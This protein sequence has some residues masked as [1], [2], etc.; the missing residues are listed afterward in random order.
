MK[1]IL[2]IDDD[3][4]LGELVRR[5][6]KQAIGKVFEGWGVELSDA[7]TWDEGIRLAETGEFDVVLLDLAIPPFTVN[8]VINRIPELTHAIKAPIIVFTGTKSN[9]IRQK[10]M[11]L[12]AASFFLKCIAVESG[13]A[14]MQDCINAVARNRRQGYGS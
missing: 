3:P 12:G 6:I 2:L 13:E 14:L 8:Q 9:E 10:C 7:R 5:K 11:A 4:D 1:R